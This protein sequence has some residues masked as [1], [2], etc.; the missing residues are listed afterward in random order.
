MGRGRWER[1]GK[2]EKVEARSLK[3]LPQRGLGR[4]ALAAHFGQKNQLKKGVPAPSSLGPTS[5]PGCKSVLPPLP[6]EGSDR[7]GSLPLRLLLPGGVAPRPAAQKAEPPPEALSAR[8]RGEA[9]RRPAV[10]SLGPPTAKGGAGASGRF[11]RPCRR[12]CSA[13]ERR[14]GGHEE[15]GRI[16]KNGWGHGQTHKHA[17]AHTCMQTGLS[18]MLSNS[19]LNYGLLMKPSLAWFRPLAQPRPKTLWLIAMCE[20]CP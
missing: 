10:P 13:A 1:R 19:W 14:L 17:Q 6:W 3:A 16:Q 11:P 5:L 20:N 18:G 12:G 4:G 2:R 15:G 7:R 8:P 9:Q